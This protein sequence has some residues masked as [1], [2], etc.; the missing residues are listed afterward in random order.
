MNEVRLF[1][2]LKQQ[3]QNNDKLT[4]NERVMI[5]KRMKSIAE[6]RVKF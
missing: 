4:L 6:K 3:Y 5:R 2:W 1:L